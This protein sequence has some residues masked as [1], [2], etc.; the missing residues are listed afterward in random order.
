MS[1]D[2]PTALVLLASE[3]LWPN[4]HSIEHWAKG[5]RRVLIY[6]TPDQFKSAEPARKLAWFC[7]ERH[8]L[9][10][11]LAEGDGN[12][13]AVARQRR[14]AVPRFQVEQDDRAHT[15]AADG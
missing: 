11:T 15:A 13:E 10:A 9:D 5:L 8:K 14:P 12:P 3:Q 1:G 2:T 7:K 6:H 4:I